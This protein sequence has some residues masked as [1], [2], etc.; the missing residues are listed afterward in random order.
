MIV[1]ISFYK[2]QIHASHTEFSYEVLW[3]YLTD[4]NSYKNPTLFPNAFIYL[5]LLVF[6]CISL[7][8]SL[9]CDW[10]LHAGSLW[11]QTA[12]AHGTRRLQTN[13]KRYIYETYVPLQQRK[14]CAALLLSAWPPSEARR[15]TNFDIIIPESAK[16]VLS[17]I[18]PVSN[19]MDDQFCNVSP[20][21][22]SSNGTTHQSPACLQ[23]QLGRGTGRDYGHQLLL[24]A[25][26]RASGS[27][28]KAEAL[29]VVIQSHLVQLKDSTWSCFYACCWV[30][31]VFVRLLRR[32]DK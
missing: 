31:P 10:W 16:A 8:F 21:G 1:C 12:L 24:P 17:E 7:R 15:S 13:T 23:T 28:F 18:A 19:V 22:N 5:F 25:L 14:K 26:Q 11:G 6:L 9:L 2:F 29:G 20:S 30:I 3:I 32:Q 27:P 4:I